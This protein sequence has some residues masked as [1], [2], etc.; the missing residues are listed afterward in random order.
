MPLS[1]DP[2]EYRY[3]EG[4]RPMRRFLVPATAAV[5]LCAIFFSRA[6]GAQSSGEPKDALGELASSYM[7]AFN[8]GDCKALA[9]F[10]TPNG[11]SVNL[12]GERFEG[13]A[14]LIEKFKR[15]FA[16]HP[17]VKLSVE[18]EIGRAHV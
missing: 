1:D 6:Q 17:E 7:A 10:W 8:K 11:E 12:Q 14:A 15:F 5:L 9:A 2:N 4:V 13:R 3:S 16:Q 18:V